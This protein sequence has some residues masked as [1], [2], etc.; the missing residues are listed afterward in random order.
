MTK[1]KQ[2]VRGTKDGIAVATEQTAQ[3]VEARRRAKHVE[4]A[5]DKAYQVF[6]K[7]GLTVGEVLHAIDCMHRKMKQSKLSSG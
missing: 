2:V 3:E 5:T 7:H 1:P 4:S 6:V